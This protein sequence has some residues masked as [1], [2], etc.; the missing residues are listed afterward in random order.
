MDDRRVLVRR[1]AGRLGWAEACRVASKAL[2][3]LLAFV[4]LVILLDKLI[5]VGRPTVYC[6][7]A[8]TALCAFYVGLLSVRRWP[9]DGEAALAIDGRLRLKE[10]ISTSLAIEGDASPMALAV[11]QD[12]TSYARSVPVAKSFPVRVPS[13][14]WWAMLTAALAIAI[15]G[16]MPQLDLLARKHKLELAK[17]EQEA[18]QE[19]AQDMR[20]K[21]EQL[22]KRATTRLLDEHFEKMDAVTDR[23]GRLAQ[24]GAKEHREG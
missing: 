1:V 3:I 22:K 24:A 19:E 16:A 17:Q 12:A 6:V 2:L 20:R 18:V 15:L 10:R 9:N 21:L 4:C 11:V 23:A 8:A 5:F 7:G 14:F 13:T